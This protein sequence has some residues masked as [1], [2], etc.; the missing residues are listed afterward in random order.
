MSQKTDALRAKTA[1]AK[2]K[3]GSP[4]AA[5][6]AVADFYEQE[7][8]RLADLGQSTYVERYEP[9]DAS[10]VDALVAELTTRG[11]PVT[12]SLEGAMHVVTVDWS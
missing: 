6:L 5:A 12:R 4:N 9:Q 1:A 2:G 3:K 10:L 7:C 11:L 8:A